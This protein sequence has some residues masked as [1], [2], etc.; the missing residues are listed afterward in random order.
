MNAIFSGQEEIRYPN[1]T[2]QIS[3]ADGSVKR[4]DTDGTEN[5][6]FPD[7]T[8][9]I[10]KSNGERTLLLPSGQK[11]IHASNFKVLV[12]RCTLKDISTISHLETRVP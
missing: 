3:F 10:V 9:V 2:L 4:I 5:I 1:G 7:G 8:K 6:N 12:A 11:E